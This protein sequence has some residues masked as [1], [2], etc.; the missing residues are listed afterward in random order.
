MSKRICRSRPNGE[1]A[2]QTHPAF[3]VAVSYLL[4]Y[5]HGWALLRY[6]SA[7]HLLRDMQSPNS[8]AHYVNSRQYMQVIICQSN[9]LRL[10]SRDTLN[11]V[12]VRYHG[13]DA[14]S[15]ALLVSRAQHVCSVTMQQMSVQVDKRKLDFDKIVAGLIKSKNMGSSINDALQQS[16]KIQVYAKGIPSLAANFLWSYFQRL[17]RIVANFKV[18]SK[19]AR[20][21]A[22]V[23][24]VCGFLYNSCICDAPDNM[25][26]ATCFSC[27]MKAILVSANSALLRSS[28]FHGGSCLAGSLAAFSCFCEPAPADTSLTDNKTVCVF[29][30]KARCLRGNAENN[31]DCITWIPGGRS[32]ALLPRKNG[33]SYLT[34]T[35]GDL[36]LVM[37]DVLYHLTV[38]APTA[39]NLYSTMLKTLKRVSL[40]VPVLCEVSVFQ[41][42]KHDV[43]IIRTNHNVICSSSNTVQPGL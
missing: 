39:S 33:T 15:F 7:E 13:Y 20:V 31:K 40:R 27:D 24:H 19:S 22:P 1:V 16:L 32:W 35:V 30:L 8:I 42:M 37:L 4:D 17:L 23:S 18:T 21:D 43:Q 12:H 9:I 38:S 10:V 34:S 36:D 3:N 25:Y 5:D 6:K 26:C 2:S 41:N 14:K 28:W 29:L 11:A